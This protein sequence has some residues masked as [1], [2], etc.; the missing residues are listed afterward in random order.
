MARVT[1]SL[2]RSARRQAGLTLT[3]LLVAMTLG[4][5]L[6]SG[7]LSVFLG[8]LQTFRNNDALARIQESGRFAMEVLRRDLR[9]AGYYGCR[10]SL[11]P[12]IP[13]P[14]IVNVTDTPPLNPGFVRNTLAP[15]PAAGV[16]P[17][18]WDDNYGL[19]LEGFSAADPVNGGAGWTLALPASALIAG[20]LDHSDIV[21]TTQA[22]GVGVEVGHTGGVPPG[23]DWLTVPVPNP[24]EANQVMLVTDCSSAAVFLASS[25]PQA[26]S[27]EHDG[28]NYTEALGRSFN[29]AEVYAAAKS[30]FYVAN[31][32]A[33][34]RPSLFRNGEELI[35]DV[36]RMR[37][38]FGVDNNDDRRVDAYLA[39]GVA[40]LDGP[41]A[42]DPDWERVVAVQVH[43][44]VSSGPEDGIA[45]QPIAVPFAG[46]V[47][48]APDTRLYQPFTAT[49]GIR[50][51]LP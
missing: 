18:P 25:D 45:E 11:A 13:R 15:G 38:F 21:A 32:A 42:T 41:A 16:D 27:I 43:L 50:N 51:R 2:H 36:E 4:L 19:P 39:A 22:R 24:L 9:M 35:E 8:G 5:F 44:L 3:E 20:A 30:V 23:V 26:G 40:P 31:S 1:R 34:G 46:G 14:E 49:I 37:V 48:N 17:L 7:V 47:F 6:V 29:G 33:T 12:E 28:G 10:N